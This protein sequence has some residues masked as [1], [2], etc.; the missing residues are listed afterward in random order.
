M[1]GTII[2]TR[3]KSIRDKMDILFSVASGSTFASAASYDL[4]VFDGGAAGAPRGCLFRFK[5]SILIMEGATNSYKNTVFDVDFGIE[6]LYTTGAPT[7]PTGVGTTPLPTAQAPK[8]SDY[9]TTIPSLT[10]VSAAFGGRV[11]TQFDITNSNHA[12]GVTSYIQF[13]IDVHGM[14]SQA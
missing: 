7:L 4:P 1:A 14:Q 13:L 6:S 12:T 10:V 8:W 11:F 9:T 3:V 2:T 5:G